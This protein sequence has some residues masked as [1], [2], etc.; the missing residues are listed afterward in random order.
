LPRAEFVIVKKWQIKMKYLFDIRTRSILIGITILLVSGCAGSR[1][2]NV[3]RSHD[4]A[5]PAPR[6]IA[7][8]TEVELEYPPRHESKE[9]QLDAATQAGRSLNSDLESTLRA[10]HLLVVNPNEKPDILLYNRVVDVRQGKRALRL[11]V[12]YGAGRAEL[13]VNTS[14]RL[15]NAPQAPLLSF[16]A[17]STTGTMPG[18]V[19]SGAVR[20]L[21]KDGL[22]VE[23]TETAKLIDS[24]LEKYFLARGW[25][26]PKPSSTGNVATLPGQP[27]V[28]E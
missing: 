17:K 8:Q 5:V 25:P 22:E 24:E 19:I 9:I 13:E 26:Y 15:P 23:V 1:V 27:G 16:Q 14:L 10:R 2:N 6:T 28:S 4:V 7:V 21:G 11:F 20:S 18:N 3:V 12:G